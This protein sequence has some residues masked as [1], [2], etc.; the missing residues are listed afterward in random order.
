MATLTPVDVDTAGQAV[1][2][3]AATSGGDVIATSGHRDVK[4]IVTNGSG[5]SITVTLTGVVECSQ[6][7]THDKTY[8]VAASAT[9][10]IEV[11]AQCIDPSNGHVAV[12][13]SSAT[14]VTVAAVA[15]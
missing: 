4:L 11:P 12:G 13:Y 14:S 8:T 2:F 1:T 10:E 15:G 3:T 5:A 9:K 7:S 6:G